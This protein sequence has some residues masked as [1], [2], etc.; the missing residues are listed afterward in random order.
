MKIQEYLFYLLWYKIL[1]KRK[2]YKNEI[3]FNYCS[4]NVKLKY[5]F[6]FNILLKFIVG[7]YKCLYK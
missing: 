1:K 2:E 4:I 5:R 7:D 6:F 3:Y